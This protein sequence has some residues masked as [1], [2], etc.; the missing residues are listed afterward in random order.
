MTNYELAWRSLNCSFSQINVHRRGKFRFQ[1]W[2]R[3]KKESNEEKET[4]KSAISGI[5]FSHTKIWINQVNS[6]E[7]VQTKWQVSLLFFKNWQNSLKSKTLYDVKHSSQVKLSQR[8]ALKNYKSQ[9]Q[10]ISIKRRR[11][12]V[13]MSSTFR[14]NIY[15]KLCWKVIHYCLERKQK[16]NKTKRE[17]PSLISC[18]SSPFTDSLDWSLKYSVIRFHN[19][20]SRGQMATITSHWSGTSF[21]L[22]LR[23]FTGK[24]MTQKLPNVHHQLHSFDSDFLIRALF[25]MIVAVPC[26]LR[27][28]C[29]SS[30][31]KCVG[32]PKIMEE[33][34]CVCV[35]ISRAIGKH[36]SWIK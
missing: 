9:K 5:N 1:F 13:K 14:T 16:K 3:E 22:I 20:E 26:I 15:I 8:F 21:N 11:N 17:L 10:N 30:K 7:P 28:P 27:L 31:G 35:A 24:I 33:F 18:Y 4:V 19:N 29:L 25:I 36:M 6:F 23:N 34:M 2:R 12:G 32:F